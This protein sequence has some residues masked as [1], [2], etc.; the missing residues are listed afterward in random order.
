MEAVPSAAAYAILA[1]PTAAAE[2]AAG[3]RSKVPGP[4]LG[5]E[6]EPPEPVPPEP[7]PPEPLLGEPAVPPAASG[8]SMIQ[9]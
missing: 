3:P 7:V 6:P 8:V 4:T 5:E 9:V 2:A 1:S